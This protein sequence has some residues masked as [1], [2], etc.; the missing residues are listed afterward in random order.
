MDGFARPLLQAKNIEFHFTHSSIVDD[1]KIGEAIRQNLFFIFKEAINNVVKYADCT[2]CTVTL[3]EKNRQISC[4]II[5]DGKGFDTTFPT[6][7]NGILNMQLRAKEMKGS[8]NIESSF[9]KGTVVKVQ[10]VA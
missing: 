9:S 8:F 5:D 4:V 1:Q 7:R 10:I 3:E 2:T 6:E